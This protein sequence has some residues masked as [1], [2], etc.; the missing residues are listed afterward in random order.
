MSLETLTSQRKPY[1]GNDKASVRYTYDQSPTAFAIMKSVERIG[2][3][4][5]LRNKKTNIIAENRRQAV[6][7]VAG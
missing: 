5:R 4:A 1:A 7:K 3:F 6:K 2:G